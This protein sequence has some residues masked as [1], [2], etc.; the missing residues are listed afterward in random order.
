VIPSA[1][2]RVQVAGYVAR[3]GQ[4]ELEQ[5]ATALDAIMAA[6][7]VREDGDGSKVALTRRSDEIAEVRQ[8][9]IEG[10]LGGRV[11]RAR[12]PAFWTGMFSSFLRPSRA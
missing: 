2:L 4:V 5:G 10:I 1:Y 11:S 7:G 8:I 12:R 9:N 6:G 3:P